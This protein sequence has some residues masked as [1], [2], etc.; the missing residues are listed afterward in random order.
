MGV[1][2]VM[3]RASR[4][5]RAADSSP[6]RGSTAARESRSPRFRGLIQ[7]LQALTNEQPALTAGEARGL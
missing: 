6:T 3:P 5:R 4:G 2:T 7:S 1:S